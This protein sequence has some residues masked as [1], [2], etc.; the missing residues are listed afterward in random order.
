MADAWHLIVRTPT[1]VDVWPVADPA[2]DAELVPAQVAAASAAAGQPPD[3]L[4]L[5]GY[6]LAL[7]TGFPDRLPATPPV[8]VHDHPPVTP[9]DFGA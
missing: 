8:T 9:A 7:V 3:W 1:T 4:G 2:T 6:D 5:D